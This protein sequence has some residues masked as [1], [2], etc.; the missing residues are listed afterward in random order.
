MFIA[1]HCRP[2]CSPLPHGRRPPH[3]LTSHRRP[4]SSPLAHGRRPPHILTSHRRPRSSPLPHGRRPP[5]GD[6]DRSHPHHR[7]QVGREETSPTRAEI[8]L[9]WTEA[10]QHLPPAAPRGHGGRRGG[11]GRPR[12]SL[13][14]VP[15]P[16][17]C[18]QTHVAPS[19]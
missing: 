3:I 8:R 19:V 15:L 16:C 9:G 12:P 2:L 10:P 6:G 14:S 1:S 7:T 11:E 5:L 13:R 18:E 4:R 17:A